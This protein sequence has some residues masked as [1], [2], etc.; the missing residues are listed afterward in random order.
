VL[1]SGPRGRSAA[2]VAAARRILAGLEQPFELGDLT[3]H[4]EAS[5]GVAIFPD[6]GTDSEVLLQ[7]ADVAMYEAK[8]QHSGCE[9]YAAERDQHSRDR[10]TLMSELRSA[11]DAGQLVVHYQ[12]KASLPGGRVIGVEALVRWQHPVRGLLGP[13]EFIPMA[14]QTGLMRPLTLFV[15]RSAL[16]QN[17]EWRSQGVD[18]SVAVNLAVPNLLDVELVTDVELMLREHGVA[19]EKLQL[20]ITEDSVMADPVRASE[21]LERF[22]GLGV[23]VSLDD[24]GTGYSSLAYLKRLAVDELKIDRSF[25]MDMTTDEEDAVIVRSTV[26]LAKNLGLRVVAEGVETTEAWENLARMGCDVAQGYLLAKPLPPAEF[27]A[28][29]ADRQLSAVSF[30]L[31]ELVDGELAAES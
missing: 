30:Q 19:P 9:L 8:A 24:F 1:V 15:M 29:I 21:V 16:A 23:G 18:L 25:V 12:P 11:I 28:W 27:T 10:L 31:S 7:R 6:H 22:R 20:E 14:E 2:G 13:Y 4:V 26:D 3:L 17:A 5:I